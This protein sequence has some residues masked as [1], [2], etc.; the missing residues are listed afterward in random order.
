MANK[1]RVLGRRIG[2]ARRPK[3]RKHG[4]FLAS[5]FVVDLANAH[6]IALILVVFI[7]I[8]VGVCVGMRAEFL[9]DILAKRSGPRWENM[10][11]S[12]LSFC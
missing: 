8:T 7:F 5:A 6:A 1:G 3:M 12:C 2:G 4:E 10:V 9:A 11:S